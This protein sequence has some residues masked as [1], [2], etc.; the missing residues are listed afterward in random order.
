M[1]QSIGNA[2]SEKVLDDASPGITRKLTPMWVKL[3]LF[4]ATT[5]PILRTTLD[6]LKHGLQV[7]LSHFDLL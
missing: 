6:L 3:K 5:N 4:K 2:L 7:F 1:K